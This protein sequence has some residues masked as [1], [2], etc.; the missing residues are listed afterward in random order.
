MEFDFIISSSNEPF[1][2]VKKFLAKAKREIIL[3]APYIKSEILKQILP[4]KELRISVITSWKIRDILL[5]ASDLSLYQ[6]SKERPFSLFLNN[7]IHLK[8]YVYD[9]EMLINGSAN[10]T[11]NGLGISA[12]YNY[13][14]N[15]IAY[16]I[17]INTHIYLKTILSEAT[18]VTDDIYNLILDAV[19][20]QPS[21]PI[22]DE[23][24]FE[25]LKQKP[26][27]FLIS[28]LPMSKDPDSLFFIYTN[29][30]DETIDKESI[31][32]AIHDIVLYHI[33]SG[34]NKHEFINHLKNHFFKSE[35]IKKLINFIGKDGKYFGQVKEWI[36]RNCHDVP[37]PSR[38]DLT[39]NIQVLFKWIVELS[40]GRYLYDRPNYS[41]RL[42][43]VGK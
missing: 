42:Y 38:R 22:I 11:N 16:S 14:L 36:Q 39:S 4:D 31:E 12:N 30:F 40:D 18:L 26:D 5:M 33:I 43:R 15:S 3:F 28:S 25:N 9:W 21:I 19:K 37:V 1:T 17:D 41:Q 13:E 34:L 2:Q 35:F 6:L 7:R 10:V 29:N 8:T 27:D 24:D 20:N 32:C 23:L